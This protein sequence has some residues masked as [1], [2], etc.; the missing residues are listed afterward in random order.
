MMA[1]IENVKHTTGRNNRYLAMAKRHYGLFVLVAIEVLVA[2]VTMLFG[3]QLYVTI[4]DNLDSNIALVK[5]FR[6]NNCWIDRSVPIPFLGG[7]DRSLLNCGYTIPYINYWLFDTEYAYWINYIV[8]IAISG[9][10]FYFLGSSCK[11]MFSKYISPNLFCVCGIIYIL[12][13]IWPSAIIAFSL[14]PWWAYLTLEICRS[15]K[16][17][18]SLLYL[19][20]MYNISGPLIGVFLLFYT[21]VFFSIFM[22]YNKKQWKG[23][24][25]AMMFSCISF[26]LLYRDIIFH[27]IQNNTTGYTIKSLSN[28]S[29]TIY[30][31]GIL[32]CLERMVNMILLKDTSIYHSGAYPLNYIAMP[33]VILFAFLFNF[34]SDRLKVSR[35]YLIGYNSLVAALLF[36]AF[37]A[38]FNNC[39]YIRLVIPFLSGFSFARFMW[40][41]PFIVILALLMIIHFLKNRGYLKS[42]LLVLLLLPLS[43]VLDVNATPSSSMYN[44]LHYNYEEYVMHQSDSTQVKWSEYYSPVLFES[45]KSD[46]NYNGEW[47]VAY[48]LEP[49]VLQYNG[50]RTLDGYYSNY[51]L[52]YHQKW[53]QMIIPVLLENPDAMQYWQASNGQRAYLYSREWVFPGSWIDYEAI[54]ESDLLIDPMVLRELGCKYVLSNID[55][56]NADELGLQYVGL[57][58]DSES[59]YSIRVYYIN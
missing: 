33:L 44:V 35:S 36:N 13:G 10:G 53:E 39:Y 34:E 3:K 37:A 32:E 43:I 30:D 27:G 45:I 24:L 8:A 11:R 52:D 22:I 47:V 50:Y 31:D 46:I 1:G 16:Y 26:I 21:I 42:I 56:K 41:S 51:S 25:I 38:S 28:S 19:P 40:L 20:L 4:N 18:L 7:V 15:R 6:D 23:I 49:A 5:M 12:I 9:L 59:Q 14:I 58:S 2:I 54:G 17:I 57:W 55:I 29:G 48:G